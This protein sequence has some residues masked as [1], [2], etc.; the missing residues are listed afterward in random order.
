MY[1]HRHCPFANEMIEYLDY[2]ILMEHRYSV[3]SV[4]IMRQR[5]Q[6]SSVIYQ[7][8]LYLV[9]YW[10]LSRSGYSMKRTP[11]PASE[12]TLTAFALKR[13]TFVNYTGTASC[14][15]IASSSSFFVLPNR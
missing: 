12:I 7:A 2:L 4:S 3:L 9:R 1:M 8:S 15:L 14:S 10:P 13:R 11:E 5:I 6:G